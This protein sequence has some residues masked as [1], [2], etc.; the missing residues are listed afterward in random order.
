[1]RLRANRRW[2]RLAAAITERAIHSIVPRAAV[3]PIADALATPR[4]AIEA[5][6]RGP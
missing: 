1:M 4:A 6:T 2:Q 5:R 3:T